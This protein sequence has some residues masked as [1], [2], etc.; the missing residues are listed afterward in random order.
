VTLDQSELADVLTTLADMTDDGTAQHDLEVL[1]ESFSE[2][3]E[4]PEYWVCPYRDEELDDEWTYVP[5]HEERSFYGVILQRNE[6]DPGSFELN[7]SWCA[8]GFDHGADESYYD[9]YCFKDID[10]EDIHEL[11]CEHS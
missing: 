10:H 11:Y 9:W 6:I 1:A 3:S 4:L 8:F 7:W 5:P 2:D